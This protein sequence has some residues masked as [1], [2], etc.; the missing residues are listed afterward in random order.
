MRA[1]GLGVLLFPLA[2]GA[3]PVTLAHQGRLL[4]AAGGALNGAQTVEVRLFGAASG[5]A[6][7]FTESAAVDVQDGF[8]SVVL[9]DSSGNPLDSAVLLNAGGVWSEV[10]VG[11]VVLGAR[12]ALVSVPRAVVATDVDGGTVTASSVTVTGS[13]QVVLGQDTASACSVAGAL[14]YDP[15]LA[16]LKVCDGAQ[17]KTLGLQTV[18]NGAGGRTWSDGSVARSCNEY[19]HPVDAGHLYQ[20]TVGDGRYVIDPDGAG[21]GASWTAYCDM[22]TDGGGWTILHAITG[23][24]GEQPLVSNAEV[25]GDPMAFAHYNT[26][27]A[28]KMGVSAV[29]TETLFLRSDGRWLRASAPPFDGNLNTPNTHPHLNVT[30]TAR[31]GATA[32]AVMGYSNL[33]YVY[34]GDFGVRTGAFDH[35][36]PS[37]YHLQSSCVGEY[38]YSYSSASA[39]SDAGYD[40]NTSLGDWTATSA[41]NSA[42]GGLLVFRTAA[43]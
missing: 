36:T 5:G 27:R 35:H 10:S 8:Y 12:Q 31:D 30:L 22:A 21:A 43:R 40:V 6:A 37:Y 2:A 1:V 26:S 28:K 7:L 20:G 14:I 32:T 11:G 4:D 24:N 34:G 13:G 18:V 41:C 19:L 29:S 39:D 38:L 9:G 15:T 33:N 23:A 17:Y 25:A 42:E 16:T 3:T